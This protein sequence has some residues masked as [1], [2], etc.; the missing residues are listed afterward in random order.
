M[1]KRV[2]EEEQLVYG[3]SASSQPATAYPGFGIFAAVAPTD[4]A[5]ADTLAERVPEMFGAFAAEGPTA[6]E[7]EVAKK[8]VANELDEA[9]REPGYWTGVLSDLAY[10][11][12]KLDEVVAAPEAFAAL[13]A[14]EVREAFARYFSPKTRFEVTLRPTASPAAD[15]ATTEEA[16]DR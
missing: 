15:E 16:E 13:T 3:I 1:I 5:K 2:R 10:R 9:V 4:P 11:G 14:E 12:T 8:Q 7:M 6:E